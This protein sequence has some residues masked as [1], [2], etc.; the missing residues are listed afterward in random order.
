[1][2]EFVFG[3]KKAFGHLNKFS[4]GKACLY[5]LVEIV[6]IFGGMCIYALHPY[7][8]LPVRWTKLLLAMIVVGFAGVIF[9]SWLKSK[10]LD[11]ISGKGSFSDAFKTYAIA[12]YPIAFGCILFPILTWVP[13][14]LLSKLL[15]LLTI[16]LAALYSIALCYKATMTLFKIDLLTTIWLEC[17]MWLVLIVMI[18]YLR[19]RAGWLMF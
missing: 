15:I 4:F 13:W 17:V 12:L 7:F 11:M 18:W 10:A 14:V 8:A 9:F 5:L 3:Y 16:S 2:L 6:L 19:Y 1:M